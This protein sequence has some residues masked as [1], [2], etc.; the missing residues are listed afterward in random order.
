[1][2]DIKIEMLV[3]EVLASKHWLYLNV[4]VPIYAYICL[5]IDVYVYIHMYVHTHLYT[6]TFIQT[7]VLLAMASMAA[8]RTSTLS[9]ICFYYA[10]E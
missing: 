1:M 7:P 9:D 5:Y 4:W 2:L 10:F 8:F 6:H 3:S